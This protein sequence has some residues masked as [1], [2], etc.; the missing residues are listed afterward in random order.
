MKKTSLYLFALALSIL[1][2]GGSL[3]AE[4]SKTAN[5]QPDGQS[6]QRPLRVSEIQGMTVL[7]AQGQ[8][9]GKID[10]L[11][12]G[13]DGMV[14]YA[15]LSHGGVLGIGD[16]LIP[17]PWKA[18]KQ[19]KDEKTLIVNISKESL[20]KAPSFDPKEW[21]NFTEPDWRKRVEVHYELPEPVKK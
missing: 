19:G 9:I 10:E 8:K 5:D 6:L 16:R 12:I 4:P 2:A 13:T 11:V 15:I 20:E 1:L 14:K 21:P 18:V 17:I 3:A 7:T